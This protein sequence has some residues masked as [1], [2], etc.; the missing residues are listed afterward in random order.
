MNEKMEFFIFLIENYADYKET[1]ADK[2][3]ELWDKLELTDTIYNL[4]ELYHVE[5]LDNAFEDI[6]RR[7]SEKNKNTFNKETLEAIEDARL[8]RNLYGSYKTAEEA[9]KAMLEE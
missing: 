9:I 7:I 3:L 4:Y 6:D 8:Q 1:T 2:V 5:S